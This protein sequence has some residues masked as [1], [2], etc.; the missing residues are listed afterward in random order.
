V[1]FVAEGAALVPEL[2]A[3][4]RELHRIPELG[5]EL[6]KTQRRVLDALDGLGLEITLG[7]RTTSIAAVLRGGKPAPVVL[8]RGDMDALPIEE[9]TGLG[10]ASTNGAMHACGHDLHTAG[11]IGAAKILAAHRDELPGTVLF[12]FQPGEE[13]AGGAKAMLDEGLLDVAGE[14]PMAAYGIHV[15]P[16]EFGVFGT[17]R[18]AIAAGAN[19]LQITVNGEGGHGSMPHTAVD[20]VPALAEMVTALHTM[21]SRRFSVFDPVILTAT[22]LDASTAVNVIPSSAKLAATVRTLSQDS[23]DTM[24]ARTKEL[25]DGIAAAHGCTADVEFTVQYPVT[26]NDDAEA[27]RVLETLGDLFGSARAIAVPQPGIGSEDFSFVLQEVPG[28]FLMLQCSPPG[29]D[30]STAAFNQSPTVV[31]DDAVLGDQAAAL[32]AIA[33]SRLAA[34]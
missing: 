26:I 29:T 16:G 22:Q 11:L 12:M 6:P 3:L 7:E 14:R 28:A 25:A 27:D 31:F 4:R 18:G 20:P 15:A 23:V 17:R 32:A 21:T 13:G 10:F 30:P 34:A 5:L 9:R 2:V 33:W 1:D 8:L 24:I 19:L